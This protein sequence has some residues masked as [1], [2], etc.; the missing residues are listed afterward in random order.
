LAEET[1]E[2][3]HM[4]K[5]VWLV[6]MGCALCGCGSMS[7]RLAPEKLEPANVSEDSAIVVLSTGAAERC[8]SAATMLNLAPAGSPHGKNGILGINVDA[9]AVKSD[10]S[11]H[12][13]S[14]SA[15]VVKPGSYQ[16]YPSTLNPYIS[17]MKVPRAEFSVAAGEVLYIGEFFM[18]VACSTKGLTQFRDQET[19]DLSLLKERNPQLSTKPIVKRIA[20]FSGY[21]LG[22]EA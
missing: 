3:E 10:F 20:V 12:Q 2:E 8:V 11:D 17:P 13:G 1:E 14:L 15:F 16:L 22:T 18:P 19:R 4:S 5:L 9:Y 6:A 7:N 21:V